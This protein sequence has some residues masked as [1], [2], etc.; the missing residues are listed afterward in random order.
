MK[1][2]LFTKL[3]NKKLMKESMPR[4]HENLA[5]HVL[6]MIFIGMKVFEKNFTIR[7][8]NKDDISKDLQ[9]IVTALH[10]TKSMKMLLASKI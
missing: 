10:W 1:Q 3:K 9:I 6:E 2:S 8:G 7:N 5:D 4:M